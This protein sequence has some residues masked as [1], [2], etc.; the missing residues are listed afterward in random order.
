MQLHRAPH[1]Q[2]LPGAPSASLRPLRPRS[3]RTLSRSPFQ[4]LHYT[5]T[6]TL[7][8]CTPSHPLTLIPGPDPGPG[9]RYVIRAYTRTHSLAIA[10]TCLP[11]AC[12]PTRYR[13]STRAGVRGHRACPTYLSPSRSPAGAPPSQ[14]DTTHAMGRHGRSLRGEERKKLSKQQLAANAHLSC[15]PTYL[16]KLSASLA[17]ALPT[18]SRSPSRSPS[19]LRRIGRSIL[20]A[21]R[22]GTDR[23]GGRG[24]DGRQGRAGERERK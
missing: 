24:G 23:G 16:R 10:H 12:S 22:R 3:S 7:T 2:T 11:S 18:V 15:V 17:R 9:L 5:H 13:A 6:Y 4:L 14:H 19:P 20:Q 21:W 8:P 1:T